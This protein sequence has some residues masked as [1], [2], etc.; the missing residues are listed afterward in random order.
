MDAKSLFG[1]TPPQPRWNTYIGARYVPIFSNVNNGVW[2]STVTYEPLT[3]VSWQGNSFTSKTFVPVGVDISNTDY[4]VQTGNYNAQVEQYRQEVMQ[5][6]ESLKTAND[7]RVFN[8]TPIT[9]VTPVMRYFVDGINGNDSNTGKDES[10]PV[11]TLKEAFRRCQYLYND[12]RIQILTAGNYDCDLLTFT[13]GALHL[14]AKVAGVQVT[15][16]NQNAIFYESHL[17]ITGAGTGS[18]ITLVVPFVNSDTTKMY[19]DGGSLSAR[20]VVFNCYLRFNGAYA[21]FTNCSFRNVYSNN[22]ELTFASGDVFTDKIATNEAA[23][24]VVNSQ[25]MLNSAVSIQLTQNNEGDVVYQRGGSFYY[26]GGFSQGGSY[27]YTGGF[28]INHANLTMTPA[29][30]NQLTN[31]CEQGLIDGVVLNSSIHKNVAQAYTT[32]FTTTGTG[33]NAITEF[34]IPAGAYI[35]IVTLTIQTA[36]AYGSIRINQVNADTNTYQSFSGGLDSVDVHYCQAT[37][38]VRGLTPETVKVAIN[39]QTNV[40][41]ESVVM[42]YISM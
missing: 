22:S 9:Q 32:A 20:D 10:N 28:N 35:A 3:I 1:V 34:T 31:I 39:T 27:K 38:F 4:W 5:L 13:G 36:E 15:F 14:N 16:T 25:I 30:E 41:V 7:Q 24:R 18:P 17:N 23:M 42:R 21:G 8:N 11:R 37:V 29:N 12:I 26:G 19:L 33:W 6:A 2:T 40:T